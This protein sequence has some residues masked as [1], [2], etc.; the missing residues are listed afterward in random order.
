MEP[1][2]TLYIY[3]DGVTEAF[4]TG[5]EMFGNARL[6]AL[7]ATESTAALTPAEL[8]GLVKKDLAAYTQ[9]AHQSDDIT[10][11]ALRYAGPRAR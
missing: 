7:L 4:N 11:L 3:T 9:G 10:M 2:E 8:H 1:G 6:Q 5:D